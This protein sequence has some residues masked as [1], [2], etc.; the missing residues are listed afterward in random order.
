VST[1][2]TVL[3]AE[4]LLHRRDHAGSSVRFVLG[5]NDSDMVEINKHAVEL[6]LCCRSR[7]F[8][9]L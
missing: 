8:S 7:H 5:K 4:L 9:R 6:R 3:E 1:D 2:Q